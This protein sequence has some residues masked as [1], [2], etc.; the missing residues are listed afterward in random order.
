MLNK[1]LFQKLTSEPGTIAKINDM[2]TLES[3][4]DAIIKNRIHV[5]IVI[6]SGY[7]Y[8]TAINNK[9]QLDITNLD[10]MVESIREAIQKH[11]EEI[12]SNML[13]QFNID[14]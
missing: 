8:Q 3:Y 10:S 1:K 13:L 14:R 4:Q 2:Y 6:E 9:Y 7:K 11:A 12:E 5:Q